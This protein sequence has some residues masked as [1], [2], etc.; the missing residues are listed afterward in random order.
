[1]DLFPYF[2]SVLDQDRAPVVLCGLDHII[3]YMNPEIGRASCREG[4]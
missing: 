3:L 4:V 2:K 1:M